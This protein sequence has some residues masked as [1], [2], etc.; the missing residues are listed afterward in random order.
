MKIKKN[1]LVVFV[2]ALQPLALL[3]NACMSASH[4]PI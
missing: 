4:S 3:V 1:A 2:F